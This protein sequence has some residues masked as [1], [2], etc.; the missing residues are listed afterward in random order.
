VVRRSLATIVR[1]KPSSTIDEIAACQ[2][3]AD[4]KRRM[5]RNRLCALPN[6]ERV[7]FDKDP[8]APVTS[9]G[10]FV[11]NGLVD[12]YSTC[13]NRIHRVRSMRAL[14]K[15]LY[16]APQAVP[17]ASPGARSRLCRGEH[18]CPRSYAQRR[19]ETRPQPQSRASDQ[20]A[21]GPLPASPKPGAGMPDGQARNQEKAHRT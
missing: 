15:S 13:T 5:E 11:G 6:P 10:A 21:G 3:P 20:A 19:S 14:T 17:P 18:R 1:L 16:T 12:G 8:Y 7:H 4:K 2:R 9:A